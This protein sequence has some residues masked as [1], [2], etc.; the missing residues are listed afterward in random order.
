MLASPHPDIRF[1]EDFVCDG[2]QNLYL[3]GYIR[4]IVSIMDKTNKR[5]VDRHEEWD[6]E[7]PGIY[8]EKTSGA[9]RW[10][11]EVGRRW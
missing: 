2:T 4:K 3:P 7:A 8:A 9:A 11:R 6:R 1:A 10:W 5:P